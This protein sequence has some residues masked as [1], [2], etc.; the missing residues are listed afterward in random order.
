[1]TDIIED[2]SLGKTM[3]DTIETEFQEAMRRI[4]KK[5][6][7]QVRHRL[8]EVDG[9]VVALDTKNRR[10][11]HALDQATSRARHA[12]QELHSKLDTY[13][14]LA[15]KL[16][17]P[18]D[19][20]SIAWKMGSGY[21]T[22]SALMRVTGVNA[23]TFVGDILDA[24]TAPPSRLVDPIPFEWIISRVTDYVDPILALPTDNP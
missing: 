24:M 6:P 20:V 5:L 10:L 23:E 1:M 11:Q 13:T 22:C 7:A 19:V 15:R 8:A 17:H 3:A 21:E 4:R 9:A 16:I 12:D 18:G 2:T 14:Q